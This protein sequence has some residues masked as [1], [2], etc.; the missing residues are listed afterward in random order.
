MRLTS[1]D[2]NWHRWAL[3]ASARMSSV[4]HIT[5][6]YFS[7]KHFKCLNLYIIQILTKQPGKQP[8]VRHLRS[9]TNDTRGWGPDTRN[10]A[11]YKYRRLT[12]TL[13]HL[14]QNICFTITSELRIFT[15]CGGKIFLRAMNLVREAYI[16]FKKYFRRYCGL[17]KVSLHSG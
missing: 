15:Y 10:L 7:Y 3:L 1:L 5:K 13:K 8:A 11:D 12:R 2:A 9:L 16:G 6:E 14:M 4:Q 17:H